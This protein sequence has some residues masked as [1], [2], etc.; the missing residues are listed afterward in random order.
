MD[1]L[2]QLGWATFV[3][4]CL[5]RASADAGSYFGLDLKT[6]IT[7]LCLVG[8]GFLLY[9]LVKGSVAAQEEAFNAFLLWGAPAI[10]FLAGLLVFH[11]FRA[12]YLI[13]VE[14]HGKAAAIIANSRRLTSIAEASLAAINSELERTASRAATAERER[15]EAR[16][17]AQ[18]PVAPHRLTPTQCARFAKAIA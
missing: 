12:P 17:V 3:W 4:R 18:Q 16:R 13:Y 11:A 6:G 5:A 14:E 9:Y 15:D 1:E 2:K 8:A 10:L 7:T